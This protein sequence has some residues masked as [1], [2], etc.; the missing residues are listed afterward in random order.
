MKK[1]FFILGI[2]TFCF[3]TG[4]NKD[5]PNPK[6][7][8]LLPNIPTNG[9]ALK[10]AKI[11]NAF[12]DMPNISNEAM[13]GTIINYKSGQVIVQTAEQPAVV[14]KAGCNVIVTI[15]TVGSVD[16][17]IVDWG[18]TNCTCNDG[19]TRRGKIISTWT[20]SYY[21][22]GTIISHTPV[23]YYVND[24]KIVGTM[25]VE[26]MGPNGNGQPYYNININGVAT[27]TSGEVVNYTSTRVRT[28][29]NGYTTQLYF[30][31]DE[32]DVTGTATAVNQDGE[33]WNTNVTTLL[34]VSVGCPFITKGVVDITPT[35]LPTRT[36]DYGNGTCDAN[37]T[38]TI[39]GQT[40][41]INVQ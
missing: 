41:E 21:D 39:N 10:N 13:S 4:C 11:Q 6:D 8:S 26:N 14:T 15:D 32:Y 7:N 12:S 22:Q 28:F 9:A 16:T 37:F 35:N 40:Y 3:F 36:I 23:N 27:L 1:L 31:D 18:N 29:S 30:L 2:G 34:H 25:T 33:G 17:L 38:V 5:N 24:N 19:K 20:G